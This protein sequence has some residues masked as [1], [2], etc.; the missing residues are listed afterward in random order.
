MFAIAA[1]DMTAKGAAFGAAVDVRAAAL[2]PSSSSQSQ[3]S[4]QVGDAS[5]AAGEGYRGR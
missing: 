4:S 2:F 5:G 1:T 3:Q